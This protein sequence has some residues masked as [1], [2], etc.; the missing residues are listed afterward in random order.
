MTGNASRPKWFRKIGKSHLFL[1]LLFVAAL[2]P[3]VYIIGS[4]MHYQLRYRSFV[5][6][7]SDS[8][9]YCYE[10]NSLQA[11][12]ET[13]TVRVSGDN[14]YDLYFLFTKK[15]AKH[16]TAAPDTPPSLTL[17]YGDGS[18]LECWSWKMEPGA[19]RTYGVFW[20]FT[21]SEGN[22]WMYD[23]DDLALNKIQRVVSL[24]LNEPW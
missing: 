8:T 13:D 10:H 17:D 23:T 6:A 16:H 20:R 7:L 21:D 2:L 1:F 22:V 12:L 5:Y 14:A 3:I 19:R 9:V 15:K 4:S 11:Q 24:S 18:L